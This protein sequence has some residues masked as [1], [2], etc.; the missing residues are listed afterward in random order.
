LDILEYEL[1]LPCI[2][3]CFELVFFVDYGT[4]LSPELDERPLIVM[5]FENCPGA[6]IL[7][8][9]ILGFLWES[10]CPEEVE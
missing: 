9:D 3:I 2:I 5:V 4:F 7:L 10:A 1:A 6:P 8:G